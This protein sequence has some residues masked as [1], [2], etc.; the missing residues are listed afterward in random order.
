MPQRTRSGARLVPE[1]PPPPE[2]DP[3]EVRAA[4]LAEAHTDYMAATEAA[5]ADYREASAELWLQYRARVDGATAEHQ[6]RTEQ[7]R[8]GRATPG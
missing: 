2:P 7:I 6:A 4:Q 1:P 5:F 8:A 3:I